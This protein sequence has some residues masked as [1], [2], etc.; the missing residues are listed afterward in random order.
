M[1]TAPEVH[2]DKIVLPGDTVTFNCDNGDLD[3]EVAPVAEGTVRITMISLG[4]R[5]A[6]FDVGLKTQ[7]EEVTA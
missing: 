2:I 5:L 7:A 1:S 3:F 6:S 4:R